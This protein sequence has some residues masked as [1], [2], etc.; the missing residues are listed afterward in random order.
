MQVLNNA[1]LNYTKNFELPTLQYESCEARMFF[2]L[3]TK[4]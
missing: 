3:K 4:E 1:H 2:T